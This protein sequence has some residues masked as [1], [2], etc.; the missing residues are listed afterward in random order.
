M[1]RRAAHLLEVERRLVVS[2][3]GG[4]D[5]EQTRASHHRLELRI[6]PKGPRSPGTIAGGENPD[7][8]ET[9]GPSEAQQALAPG[10]EH[11]L[12]CWRQRGA[13]GGFPLIPGCGQSTS[14]TA[15][16]QPNGGQEVR[17]A[18]LVERESAGLVECG[19]AADCVGEE[20]PTDLAG[21]A[22]Q[23]DPS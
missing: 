15:A 1:T 10:D 3:A 2:G 18:A 11:D 5:N 17:V 14:H 22:G 13:E 8:P 21:I 19:V 16:G 23:T 7:G 9:H 4:D 12:V 20:T 6:A